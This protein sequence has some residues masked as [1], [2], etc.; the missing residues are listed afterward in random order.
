[1]R[2]EAG[3]RYQRSWIIGHELRPESEDGT[4]WEVED[5]RWKIEAILKVRFW[6]IEEDDGAVDRAVFEGGEVSE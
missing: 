1:M 3:P 6:K 4:R 2:R 5:R